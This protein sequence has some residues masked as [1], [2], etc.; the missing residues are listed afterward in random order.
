ME[1]VTINEKESGDQ[2]L[3]VASHSQ[4]AY[5]HIKCEQLSKAKWYIKKADDI[6]EKEPYING[7]IIM[8]MYK[9]VKGIYAAETNDIAHADLYFD[10]ALQNARKN[11]LHI[12]KMKILEE[13]LNYDLDGPNVRKSLIKELNALRLKRKVEAAKIFEQEQDE[14]N[15]IINNKER[16]LRSLF[17][18]IFVCAIIIFLT[19]RITAAKRKITKR[20]FKQLLEQLRSSC[21]LDGTIR[22]RY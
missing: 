17:V 7:S 5:D 13:R 19:L 6:I 14:K 11:N 2:S 12:E 9:M 10:E 15:T 1:I 8:A 18:L 22:E 21:A 3:L 20:K 4:L 16:Q